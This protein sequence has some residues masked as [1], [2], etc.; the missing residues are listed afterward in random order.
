MFNVLV[1]SNSPT[2]IYTIQEIEEIKIVGVVSE[3][4][5]ETL[6]NKS[7]YSPIYVD[8][9]DFLQKTI[10]Q[11]KFDFIVM[12]DFGIIIPCDLVKKYQIY[13]IHPG[14]LRT[15]RGS[16]PVNWAILNDL[17][18]TVVSLYRLGD[19]IDLGELMVEHTVKIYSY[20]VPFTLKKRVEGEIPSMLLELCNMLS[21][22]RQG[23]QIDDGEYLKRIT[24]ADYTIR[25]TDP[26]KTIKAKIRSQYGFRG[27][28][29][30]KDGNKIYVST[31]EDYQKVIK[32]DEIST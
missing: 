6:H 12:Y 20:D 17:K 27:A 31:Y 23:Q 3:K 22:Q 9:K 30:Y 8:G 18:V 4:K 21:E 25:N 15:N 11:I 14:D 24:E 32:E 16:S 29:L 19:K 7:D 1:L 26:E 28:V 10:E 5:Y 13:N 2:I